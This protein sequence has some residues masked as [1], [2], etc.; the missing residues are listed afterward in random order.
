MNKK[1][2]NIL[3][4]GG[5]GYIG[6]HIVE[7]LIKVNKNII[8]LDNLKNGFKLLI[9]KKVKFIKG[10][11]LNT[12]LVEKII[13]ENKITTIM[14]LAGL[15]DVIESENNKEKYYKNNVLGTLNLIKACKKSNVKYFIFSSSAGVYGNTSKAAT[16]KMA[17]KPIN[18]YAYTKMKCEKIIKHYSKIYN[19]NY[20]I[21]RYFN[22]CGASSSGKIGISNPKNKSLFKILAKEALKKIPVINIYGI[23]HPT[24]DGSCIRDFIHVCDL[25]SIHLRSLDILSVKSKSFLINCGYGKGYSVLEIANIFKRKINKLTKIRF[26]DARKDEISISFSNTKKM[27]KILKWRPKYNNINKILKS[28]IDWEKNLNYIKSSK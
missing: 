17:L 26:K 23:E 6:S 11:I 16:E 12:K 5:A 10:D 18:Y 14:H 24:K 8:I 2:Q 28:S 9:H 1:I 22:V 3:I 7:Q 13:Q 27:K 25:A 19:Y 15:I 4:T 21:L 20:S